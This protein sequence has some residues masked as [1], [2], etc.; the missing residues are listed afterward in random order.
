MTASD[1]RDQQGA[2]GPETSRPSR[3]L[4]VVAMALVL[5]SGLAGILAARWLRPG[6]SRAEPKAPPAVAELGV[7]IPNH[8]F[9]GWDKPD[10]VLVLTGSQHGYL[11]PC[12]CSRPQKG[13]LERRHNFVQAL[14]ERGWTVAA[15]DVG[16]IAQMHGPRGLANEQ[17]LLKYVYSMRALKKIG[18]SAVSFGAYEAALPLDSALAEY[19]LQDPVPRVLAANLKDREKNFPEMLGEWLEIKD[20]PIKTG[21]TAC[22]GATVEEKIKDANVKFEWSAHALGRILPKMNKAG[23]QLR[24][25]LYQGYATSHLQGTNAG[26]P[27]GIRCAEAFPQFQIMLAL[28]EEDEPS[29]RPLMVNNDNTLIASLGH[30]GRHVGVV[31]IWR[32]Q[33]DRKPFKL[34]YQLVDM[35]EDFLTP[36]DKEEGHPIV[37]MMEEYTT[38]LKRRDMQAKFGQTK[39]PMQVMDPVADLHKDTPSIPKYVGSEKCKSCHADAYD[40]WKQTAHSHAYQTLE[41]AKRP[42]L[43]QFD[44]ECIVCHATG[45]GYHTGFTN[46]TATP[47]LKDVGCESCHGP[48]S[49]HAMNHKDKVWQERMNPWKAPA[50][51][52]AGDKAKRLS[53]L[54]I[55]CQ[56][57]HDHD[58]DVTWTAEK[59][60]SGFDKKWPKI[61]HPTEIP[62]AESK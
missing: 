46:A 32:S 57:C 28:G 61:A 33:H 48:G 15:V 9:R 49:H 4:Q 1:D 41:G 38:E 7:K 51:E 58:N 17:G 2:P 44:A 25:L 13:G 11:L 6:Q 45:F 36:K 39:H 31:G 20:L 26:K 53:R 19:A 37:Q 35:D 59:G 54:D 8:L 16:D 43:R 62:P 50:N 40:I 29:G 10:M 12:G 56:T 27:E 47:K 42:A 24:V 21:V 3:T 60:R 55:F 18:Y 23:I 5:V 14:R 52:N 34:E 22:I 30:K